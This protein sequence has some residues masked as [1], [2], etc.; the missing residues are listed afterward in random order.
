MRP[1]L[2]VI[3]RLR[4]ICRTARLASPYN[5]TSYNCSLWQ[6]LLNGPLGLKKSVFQSFERHRQSARLG[7]CLGSIDTCTT[8]V[9]R[10]HDHDMCRLSVQWLIY[11]SSQESGKRHTTHDSRCSVKR[12][13]LTPRLQGLLPY[14]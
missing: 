13:R 6:A 8:A 14:I 9:S 7:G 3:Q 10:L 1:S 12:A 4:L 5:D 11:P 2:Q